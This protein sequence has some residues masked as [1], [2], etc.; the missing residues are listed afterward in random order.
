MEC[1]LVPYLAIGGTRNDFWK[2]TP[3]T[4]KYDFMAF[5][6]KREY[7]MQ[8][9]WLQGAYVKDAIESSIFICGLADKKVINK[10]PKYP[11]MPRQEKKKKSKKQDKAETELLIA[12]MD[13][14]MERI[15]SQNIKRG[16]G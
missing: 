2:L 8:M 15:N 16:S 13:R 14:L 10:L 7:D 6:Q 5:E 11:P 3:K 12:K 9:A 1:Y 4:I